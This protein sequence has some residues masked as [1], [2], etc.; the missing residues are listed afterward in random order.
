MKDHKKILSTPIL[1]E[2]HVEMV[3]PHFEVDTKSRMV[4]IINMKVNL[5]EVGEETLKEEEVVEV[6]V[7]VIEV[8]NQIV[9]QR[10]L[11]RETWAHGKEL[12]SKGT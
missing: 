5:M 8:N 9:T 4:D 3:K 6:V 7:K 12:L 2:V 10:L 11:L 1:I